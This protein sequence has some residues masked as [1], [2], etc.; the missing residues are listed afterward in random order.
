[1]NL[2]EI[3][4]AGKIPDEIALSDFLR[5]MV[6]ATVDFYRRVG[7]VRPW[8]GYVAI[9]D[10]APVGACAFKSSPVAGR[11]EIAYVTAPDHEGQGVATAMAKELVRIARQQDERLTVIAQTLPEENASTTILK[12][13]GFTLIGSVDH[14]EDGVVWEWELRA[15]PRDESQRS[16][17]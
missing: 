14:S 1:M 2:V 5:S 12:K 10:G 15:M 4:E 8:I 11:V 17:A 6:E 16:N 3:E 9:Q 13:L 7:F